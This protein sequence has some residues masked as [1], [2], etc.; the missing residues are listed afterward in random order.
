[1]KKNKIMR[2]FKIPLC[3]NFVRKASDYSGP[4]DTCQCHLG[5]KNGV[6]Q[7]SFISKIR[8]KKN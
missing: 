4:M 2:Y 6:W 8:R 3:R 1:M 7:L 5:S